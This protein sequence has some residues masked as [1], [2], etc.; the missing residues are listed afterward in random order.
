M[1]SCNNN[2][3]KEEFL[4][5]LD[6]LNPFSDCKSWIYWIIIAILLLVIIFS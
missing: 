6:F 4:G 1:S 3:P 5:P 2:K